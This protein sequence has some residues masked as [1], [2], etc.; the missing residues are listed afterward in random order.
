MFSV[1]LNY[2]LLKRISGNRQKAPEDFQW[3]ETK[4][5]YSP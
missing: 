5:G 2:L 3:D 4:A 1:P